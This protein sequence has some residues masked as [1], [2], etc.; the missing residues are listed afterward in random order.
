MKFQVPEKKVVE[1]IEKF[2]MSY[3]GTTPQ[4]FIDAFEVGQLYKLADLHPFYIYDD[5][6]GV[7]IVTSEEHVENKGN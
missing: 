1:A 4:G 2:S 7:F 5:V 6:E 3:P